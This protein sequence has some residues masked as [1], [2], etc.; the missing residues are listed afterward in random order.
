LEGEKR[1]IQLSVRQAAK[2]RA[3]FGC[4]SN[5]GSPVNV[6]GELMPNQRERREKDGRGKECGHIKERETPINY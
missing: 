6:L 1:G 2:S 5:N 4:L 3:P